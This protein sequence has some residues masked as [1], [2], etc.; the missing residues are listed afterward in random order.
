MKCVSLNCGHNVTCGVR[1]PFF[2]LLAGNSSRFGVACRAAFERETGNLGTL[3]GER[4]DSALC[5]LSQPKNDWV[6]HGRNS[7]EGTASSSLPLPRPQGF[8]K[9]LKTLRERSIRRD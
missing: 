3:T 7:K 8:L 2:A 9:R 4:F 5:R 6:Y 1:N